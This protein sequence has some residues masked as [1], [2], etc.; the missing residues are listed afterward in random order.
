MLTC[1]SED[2]VARVRS[3]A[4]IM[5]HNGLRISRSLIIIPLPLAFHPR[6]VKYQKALDRLRHKYSFSSQAN[7]VDC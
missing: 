6:V 5:E 3:A 7:L 2:S 4:W 1:S